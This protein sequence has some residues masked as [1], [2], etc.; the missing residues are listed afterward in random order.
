MTRSVPGSADPAATLPGLPLPGPLLSGPL[1]A[2]RDWFPLLENR[3]VLLVSHDLTLTGAPLILLELA[4][5]MKDSGARIDVVSLRGREDRNAL[6][7]KVAARL[8][9]MERSHDAA[10]SADLVIANTVLAHDWIRRFVEAHPDRARRLVWWIHENDTETYAAGIA[11]LDLARTIVF[12]SH[13]GLQ[14]WQAT[15][16]CMPP[17]A[18]V[19][20]PCADG[21]LWSRVARDRDAIAAGPVRRALARIGVPPP[22][23]T[24]RAARA[25]LGVREDEFL[26]SLF[27]PCSP[28]KGQALAARTAGRMLRD[29]P[30]LPLKLLIVG[31]RSPRRARRFLGGLDEWDRRTIDSR[32]ALPMVG[33]LAPYYRATDAY[34]MNSQGRGENFGR[35]TIEAMAFGLPVLG[36]DAGGTR[37]I[38]VPGR[39]GLLHPVGE[40]GQEALA[41][42]IRRLMDDRALGRALGE[43]GRER[44]RLQFAE[45]RFYAG[46][47]D[48]IE[49]I[50]EGRYDSV[51]ASRSRR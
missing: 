15:G 19:I 10:A 21:A 2:R 44:V 45:D 29:E 51:A 28:A 48:I 5:R 41:R 40:Q 17:V 43:A 13:A 8:L 46:W 22:A 20:H 11:S 26:L 6:V 16:L 38:V 24:R 14:A 39:T 37:E 18:R 4:L 34:V 47:G 3:R 32:R 30:G 35:V 36:T 42:N 1:A 25:A 33:D 7:R 9:P 27:A 50:V 12:D 49:E 31:F 23:L